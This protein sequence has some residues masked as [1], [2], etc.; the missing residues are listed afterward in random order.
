M[1]LDLLRIGPAVGAAVDLEIGTGTD[2]AQA[3]QHG[4][5]PEIEA[6]VHVCGGDEIRRRQRIGPGAEAACGDPGG[7]ATRLEDLPAS[8]VG[9]Q[10]TEGEE[11]DGLGIELAIDDLTIERGV[12]VDQR[13]QMSWVAPDSF[14]RG[15][16]EGPSAAAG[17][18]SSRCASPSA[19]TPRPRGRSARS[20][21]PPAC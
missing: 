19:R 6:I 10:T 7:I 8:L 20:D 17:S 5:G 11:S 9:L 21:C 4:H 13:L 18:T 14:E 12:R 3:H 1:V 2:P 15:D 16:G